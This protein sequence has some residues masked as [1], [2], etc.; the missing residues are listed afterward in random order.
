METLVEKSSVRMESRGTSENRANRQSEIDAESELTNEAESFVNIDRLIIDLDGAC[1]G[2]CVEDSELVVVE[3]AECKRDRKRNQSTHD[4][5]GSFD[6]SAQS[7]DLR[8][9]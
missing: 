7:M 1:V 6:A 5:D 2:C 3:D 8:R 4:S 9:V